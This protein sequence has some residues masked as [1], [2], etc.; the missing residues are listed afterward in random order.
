ML[1][2]V[3]LHFIH[4]ILDSSSDEETPVLKPHVKASMDSEKGTKNTEINKSVKKPRQVLNRK[5][6]PRNLF[7]PEE[8]KILVEA[9]SS[10]EELNFTNLAKKMNRDYCSVKRRVKKLKLS[11]GDTTRNFSRFT[12]QEDLTIIDSVIKSLPR[13]SKLDDTPLEDDLDLAANLEAA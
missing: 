13:F 3:F 11:G 12:L 10:G 1:A 7:T 2:P 9:I 5:R 4:L 6:T 8:D